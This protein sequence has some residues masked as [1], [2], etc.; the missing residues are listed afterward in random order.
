MPKNEGKSQKRGCKIRRKK[1][2]TLRKNKIK[3]GK[4]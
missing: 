4:K 3:R 1:A 2:E